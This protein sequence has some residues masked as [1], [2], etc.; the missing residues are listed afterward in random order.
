M[1]R[2]LLI[3]SL[4][5]SG[6]LCRPAVAADRE[7]IT[8]PQ[9]LDSFAKIIKDKQYNCQLCCDIQPMEHHDEGWSYKV[10]CKNQHT[11]NVLLTPYGD[12]VVKP[13]IEK[14]LAHQ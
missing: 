14:I 11:Y 8:D 13:V 1:R 10:T 2:L 6:I 9:I 7:T 4:I 5:L 12:M 3:S